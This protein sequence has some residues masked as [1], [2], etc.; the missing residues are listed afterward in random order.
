MEYLSYRGEFTDVPLD[1]MIETFRREYT[2]D[3]LPWKDADFD[4]EV[5][6]ETQEVQD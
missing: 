1:D 2:Q 4:R 6:Q 5:E 3:E